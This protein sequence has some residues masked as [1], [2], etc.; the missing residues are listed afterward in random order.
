[1]PETVKS[2]LEGVTVGMTERPD[3]HDPAV[4]EADEEIQKKVWETVVLARA[5]HM[6]VILHVADWVT[7]QQEYPILKIT[8]KWISN[9]KVQD[10]KHLLGDEHKWRR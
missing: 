1:M 3:A 5:T 9:W 6:W 7:A 8:I 10:L 4:A 2:I